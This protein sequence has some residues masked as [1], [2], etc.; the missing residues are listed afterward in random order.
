LW[1]VRVTGTS[2][3]TGTLGHA[4]EHRKVRTTTNQSDFHSVF[5]N[6]ALTSGV[7]A[8]IGQCGG[9]LNAGREA[10]NSFAGDEITANASHG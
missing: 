8:K 3:K 5:T 6:T 7:E 1:T 2:F 10:K 9:Y 4:A